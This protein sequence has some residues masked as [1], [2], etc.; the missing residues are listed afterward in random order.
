M[1]DPGKENQPDFSLPKIRDLSD[2]YETGV[3]CTARAIK[4]DKNFFMPYVLNLFPVEKATLIST[5][6]KTE[7]V[8]PLC[9]VIVQK[10]HEEVLTE[11]DLG[12]N[13]TVIFKFLKQQYL[14]C[15]KIAPDDR[16]LNYLTA[17]ERSFNIT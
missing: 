5:V 10:I 7:V 12:L 8:E 11:E 15:F 17:L 2:I 9:R 3:L 16:F 13:D 1:L 4:D 14:K 6:S